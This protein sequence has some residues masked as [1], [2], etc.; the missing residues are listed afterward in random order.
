MIIRDPARQGT[1][2]NDQHI[3]GTFKIW[4]PSIIHVNLVHIDGMQATLNMAKRLMGVL[5]G[6]SPD[7]SAILNISFMVASHHDGLA[8]GMYQ[9][10]DILKQVTFQESALLSGLQNIH[11]S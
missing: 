8:S 10:P 2:F 11:R 5:K 9:K 1:T 7:A 3:P 6:T 4:L